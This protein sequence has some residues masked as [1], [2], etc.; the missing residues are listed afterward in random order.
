MHNVCSAKSL[1]DWRGVIDAAPIGVLAF[2]SRDGRPIACAVTPYL[3]G[4]EV[5]ITSTL[6]LPAK[7]VAAARE[8]HAALLAGGVSVRGSVA[9]SVDTT[10][11]EFD[12]WV[13]AQEL[14]K[15]PP[16]RSLLAIPGHRRLFPW[17]VGRTFIRFVDP[18]VTAGP[19]RDR[20]TL[21]TIAADGTPSIAAAP[22]PPAD[23]IDAPFA[24]SG[25]GMAC[26]LIHEETDDQAELRQVRLDG[27]VVGGMFH[28][29]RTVGSLAPQPTGI[30]ADLTKLRALRRQATRQRDVVERLAAATR[31]A[32]DSA[33]AAA[34]FDARWR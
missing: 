3:E 27:Q 24:A 32:A 4:G 28:T 19:D 12:R 1:S 17:Y 7:A 34:P 8:G 33:S 25:E 21:T 11:Q 31:P 20:S 10:G 14:R 13:R 2:R 23:R 9:V 29:T 26:L 16:A 6:A 15:Y 18:E 5:V 30:R 22:E